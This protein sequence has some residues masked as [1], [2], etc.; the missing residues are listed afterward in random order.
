MFYLN[1]MRLTIIGA[2]NS[3]KGTQGK[4]LAEKFGLFY[5][6]TGAFFRDYFSRNEVFHDYTKAQFYSGL[7]CS[8]LTMNEFMRSLFE[9]RKIPHDNYL[10][11]SYPRTISQGE[12]FDKLVHGSFDIIFLDVPREVSI[13]RARKRL[14]CRVDD[15][16]NV[17]ET[18]WR[19]FELETIPLINKYKKI[20]IVIEQ[21]GVGDIGLIN[22]QLEQK[23][24]MA[25]T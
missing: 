6:S 10:I 20:G 25:Y 15:L 22:R 24:R 13:E 8:D 2:P 5:L 14:E 4:L 3:G 18:R 17:P 12:Y 9:K 23:V 11:D 19:I 21:D 1:K 7:L 16:D